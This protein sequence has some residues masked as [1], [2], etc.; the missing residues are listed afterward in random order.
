M[1]QREL[2]LSEAPGCT[3]IHALPLVLDPAGWNQ[4]QQHARSLHNHASSPTDEP[5]GGSSLLVAAQLC[6][7]KSK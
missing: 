7:C 5:L 3:E 4:A 2:E 1:L 6:V